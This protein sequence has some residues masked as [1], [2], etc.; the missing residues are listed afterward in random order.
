MT[1]KRKLD[2]V[3]FKSILNQKFPDFYPYI[4]RRLNMA[5]LTG[6]LGNSDYDA[7]AIIESVYQGLYQRFEKMPE[8]LEQ[9]KV[10][11]YQIGEMIL[12][13]TLQEEV[14][15]ERHSMKLSLLEDKELSD[16]DEIYTIDAEGELHLIEDL[17][18]EVNP[19]QY[20]LGAILEDF[21]T[22]EEIDK[23]LALQDRKV[24]HQEIKKVLIQLPESER[25]VFDLYW[26]GGM[27]IDQIA[28]IRGLS[29]PDTKSILRKVTMLV[30]HRLESRL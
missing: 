4:V 28:E 22:L 17:E 2:L 21:S 12:E 15:E 24:L 3:S 5:E 18:E 30:K 29:G 23:I 11:V 26:L 27:E 9:L 25:T 8:Q 7:N 10:W 19:K 13:E 16:L 14:F 6:A 1:S 20:D